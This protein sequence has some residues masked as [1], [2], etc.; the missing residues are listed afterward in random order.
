MAEARK[1]VETF[2][3]DLKKRAN[4]QTT[5]R[6]LYAARLRRWQCWSDVALLVSSLILT[7]AAFID[8]AI[9]AR[10]GLGRT[11][12]QVLT[13]IIG[14]ANFA[15]ALIL[16]YTRPGARA[17]VQ[18]AARRHYTSILREVHRH[19]KTGNLEA[20]DVHD[21]EARYLADELFH[22]VPDELF[23]KYKAKHYEKLTL[24]SLVEQGVSYKEAQA[25]LRERQAQAAKVARE[26]KE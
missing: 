8:P 16:L 17:N 18:R 24:S 20:V 23:A 10:M 2:L 26:V 14:L 11:S 13:G 5:V 7:V 3:K 9:T 19:L 22:D 15:A 25:I 6:A 1:D 12:F 4:Q 21:L